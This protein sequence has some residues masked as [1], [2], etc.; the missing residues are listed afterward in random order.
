[1]RPSVG[2]LFQVGSGSQA[3]GGLCVDSV[4][5][6]RILAYGAVLWLAFSLIAI[7]F[8][9]VAVDQDLVPAQILAG[10]VHY[11]AG[12]PHDIAYRKTF[13]LFNWRICV[14]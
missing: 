12:H 14:S 1:M 7:W 10:A 9:G 6:G 11:P 13:N 5:Q 4:P 3:G 2:P 8:H